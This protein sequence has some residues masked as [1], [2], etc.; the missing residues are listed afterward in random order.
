[1]ILFVETAADLDDADDF[2]SRLGHKPG[3][4]RADIAEALHDD[5]SGIAIQAQFLDRL[6]ANH[7][8]ATPGSLTAP[9]RSAN[10]DRFAGHDGGHGL[11]SMHG[12]GVH[13]PGHDLLVGVDIR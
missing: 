12:I 7:E 5:A 10:V 3:R 1:A 4:V 2:V 9:A 8:N 13:H 11:A 6:I